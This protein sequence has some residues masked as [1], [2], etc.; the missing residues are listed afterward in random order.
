MRLKPV[1]FR[2]KRE[3]KT[4]YYKRLRL[5]KTQRARI[6]VRPALGN[7]TV[8]IAAYDQKGDKILLGLSGKALEKYGWKTHKGNVPAAYLTGY[9]LG[10]LAA[11]KNLTEAV[12]DTGLRNPVK[13]GRIYACI[14]GLCD[15]G[16]RIPVDESVLPTEDRVKGQHIA[17]YAQ[18]SKVHF[19][20]YAQKGVD[21]VALVQLFEIVKKKIEESI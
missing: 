14:K 11:K 5:L 16:I 10:R 12:L 8:Q 13:G 17:A 1:Q 6:V 20:E 3:G 21:P 2:R 4:N 18:R 15:A 19:T 9:L 7:I